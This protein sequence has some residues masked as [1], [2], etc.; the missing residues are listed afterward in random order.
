MS[1]FVSGVLVLCGTYLLSKN[2]FEQ[3]IRRLLNIPYEDL[4]LLLKIAVVFFGYEKKFKSHILWIDDG[5]Q[6]PI[7]DNLNFKLQYE[8]LE[9]FLGFFLIFIGVLIQIFFG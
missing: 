2:V 6:F 8:L 5:K 1:S 7:K 9:P 4:P 3:S